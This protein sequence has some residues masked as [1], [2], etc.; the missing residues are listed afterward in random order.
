[1]DKIQI[2]SNLTKIVECI[3]I[4]LLAVL[5]LYFAL[6]VSFMQGNGRVIN[7]AGI[8]RGAT[9]RLVKLEVAGMQQDELILFL[10]NIIDDLQNGDGNYNLRQIRDEEYHQC[11]KEQWELWQQLKYAVLETRQVGYQETNIIAL[12]EQYYQLADK[13]VAAAEHYSESIAWRIRTIGFVLLIVIGLVM[14]LL[15]RETIGT[16]T[17][18]RRNVELRKAVYLDAETGLPNKGRCQELLNEGK[19]LDPLRDHACAMFDLNNLKAVNDSYGHKAG[20][21][22][23]V[24]F[25]RLLRSSFP[26]T[27]FVGRCGGDEFVAV[28]TDV[29]EDE[30]KAHLGTLQ[31]KVKAYNDGE[32]A[33]KLSYAYGYEHSVK[34]SECTMKQLVEIADKRMYSNKRKMKQK[35]GAKE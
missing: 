9:Q 24:N 4:A 15:I 19:C 11:L 25:A 22:L 17:L 5:F 31:N 2:R 14:A 1:M 3:L 34:Y 16:I 23:I 13:T 35:N 12:S 21:V 8:V 20:D 33:L 18:A 10:D 27:V 29:S 32:T 7:Y 28:F 6:L 30:V 26:E